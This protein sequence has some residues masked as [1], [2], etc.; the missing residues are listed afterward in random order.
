MPRF[1][2]CFDDS[3]C[4]A[5]ETQFLSEGD[6]IR[7]SISVDYI[8]GGPLGM[9]QNL[10]LVSL[11]KDSILVNCLNS[12]LGDCVI[13][14]TLP[15]DERNRIQHWRNAS[16]PWMGIEI[17]ITNAVVDDSAM[18]FVELEADDPNASGTVTQSTSTISVSVTPTL[19]EFLAR[20]FGPFK[21]N[22]IYS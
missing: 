7:F 9:N 5:D 10:R 13:N 2:G 18:Y 20:I 16:N 3:P 4:M 17:N 19:S 12:N 14:P 1:V 8:P 15:A 6:N 21:L 11:L 22:V